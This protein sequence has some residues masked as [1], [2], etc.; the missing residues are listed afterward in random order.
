MRF[1]G[2]RVDIEGAHLLKQKLVQEENQCLQQVKK[3][4][5][6]ETQIWAARSIA[7]VFEKL[8]LPFDRTEKTQAPSFTKNFFTKP[9]TSDGTKD[10]TC[11]R[12][13]QSTYNLY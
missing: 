9:S 1:L 5:G 13:K 12:N 3:E 10:C 4:T 11:K 6:I 2:V 8:S 7:Q